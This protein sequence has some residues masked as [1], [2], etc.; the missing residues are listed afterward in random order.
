M[1]QPIDLCPYL[2]AQPVSPS[3]RHRQRRSAAS[4]LLVLETLISV[5][6]GISVLIGVAALLLM[7]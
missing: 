3:I 4:L 7:L 5:I 1:N 6:I 2:P